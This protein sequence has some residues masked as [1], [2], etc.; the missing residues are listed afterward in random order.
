MS[1]M[2]Q[3]V[4]AWF[5]NWGLDLAETDCV[6][7][8]CKDR[9]QFMGS[10]KPVFLCIWYHKTRLFALERC[11]LEVVDSTTCYVCF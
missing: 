6:Q 11:V 5:H 4:R 7:V 3:L 2:M 1:D 10:L 9:C 8:S